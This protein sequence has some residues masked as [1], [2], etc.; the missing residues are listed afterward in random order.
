MRLSWGGMAIVITLYK[1]KGLNISKLCGYTF[2]LTGRDHHRHANPGRRF[3]CPGLGRYWAFSPRMRQSQEQH[4]HATKI[5]RNT[6][7]RQKSGATRACGKNQARHAHAAKVRSN[8]RMRQSQEQ[9]AHATKIRRNTRMRQKSGA[10][11]ACGKNQARHAHAAKIRRNTRMR[12]KSGAT[13]ACGKNQEQHAHAAKIRRN[14]RMRQKSGATRACDKSQAQH[15]QGTNRQAQRLRALAHTANVSQ[16]A[17][18][19]SEGGHESHQR[20]G[21]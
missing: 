10:T 2:A 6:R 14:T 17:K 15:A 21:N 7:M 18:E 8:T 3:A 4:A 12:Q 20:K 16:G 5:R 19:P 11:R 1:E 9:H 13:R